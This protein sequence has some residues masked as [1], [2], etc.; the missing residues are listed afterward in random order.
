MV[1]SAL[2][3]QATSLSPGRQILLLLLYLE[4][5]TAFFRQQVLGFPS[6]CWSLLPV[7]SLGN[8]SSP[9]SVILRGFV[10]CLLVCSRLVYLQTPRALGASLTVRFI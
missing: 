9:Y 3:R 5:F 10:L 7:L 4:L 8:V 6:L 1:N 2:R